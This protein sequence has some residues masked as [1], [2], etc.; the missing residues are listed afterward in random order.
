MEVRFNHTTAVVATVSCRREDSGSA[1]CY[2]HATAVVAT[3]SCR[4]SCHCFM[5]QGRQWKCGCYNHTTAVV[6]TVSCRREDSGSACCYNHTT[7]VVATVSCRCS[8]HCF[9]SQGRQWKC[10]LTTPLL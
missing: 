8:C 4:C 9:M 1:C 10:G 2:N 6:A 7:A 5:S 3:V